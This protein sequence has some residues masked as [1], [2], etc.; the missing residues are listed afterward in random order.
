[1]KRYHWVLT[2]A[3]TGG[4][5][6]KSASFHGVVDVR[7]GG[8]RNAVLNELLEMHQRQHPEFK[9]GAVVFFSLDPDE[10]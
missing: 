2:L 1:M 3:S 7:P 4:T 9:T 5:T 6:L 8:T 10:L